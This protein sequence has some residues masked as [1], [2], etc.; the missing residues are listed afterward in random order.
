MPKT[1]YGDYG[2]AFRR[3]HAAAYP[4][5]D[6]PMA[7]FGAAAWARDHLMAHG[8]SAHLPAHMAAPQLAAG[9][10]HMVAGAPVFERPVF[11]VTSP[12]FEAASP[13]IAGR[14]GDCAAL[15]AAAPSE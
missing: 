1:V 6:T 14:I 4:D 10:L 15:L 5:G 8:G 2:E 7:T 13:W 12:R 3:D 11:F 9:K